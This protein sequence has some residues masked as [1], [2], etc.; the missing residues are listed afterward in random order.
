MAA[1]LHS[2]PRAHVR[3]PAGLVWHQ[4]ASLISLIPPSNSPN[5][6]PYSSMS[7]FTAA[8]YPNNPSLRTVRTRPLGINWQL[9]YF[10]HLSLGG[11]ARGTL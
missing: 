1:D 3:K 2:Y 6:H 10:S 9:L 11:K 4:G 8:T 5:L 7:H